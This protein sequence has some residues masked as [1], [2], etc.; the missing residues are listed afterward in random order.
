MLFSIYIPF[1]ISLKLSEIRDTPFIRKMCIIIINY[2]QKCPFKIDFNTPS[3]LYNK[4]IFKFSKDNVQIRA[5][6]SFH[7]LFVKKTQKK[8]GD[9]YRRNRVIV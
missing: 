1:K 6:V 5:K 8:P 3:L 4:Y 9:I 2:V 7:K